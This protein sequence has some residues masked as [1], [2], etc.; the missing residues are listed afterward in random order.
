[1]EEYAE[2]NQETKPLPQLKTQ[3]T[4]YFWMRCYQVEQVEERLNSSYLIFQM[5]NSIR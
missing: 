4:E 3:M 5:R 1:V 2:S